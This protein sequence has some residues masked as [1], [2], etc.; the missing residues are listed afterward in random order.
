MEW[1]SGPQMSSAGPTL[2][3]TT[4]ARAAFDSMA[5][6]YNLYYFVGGGRVIRLRTLAG[7]RR[8]ASAASI[9]FNDASG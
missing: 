5:Y 4:P 2:S 8:A 3:A 1:C 9:F 7:R 6:L